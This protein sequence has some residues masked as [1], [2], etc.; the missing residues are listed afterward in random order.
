MGLKVIMIHQ[1]FRLDYLSCLLTIL[2]TILI[3]RKRWAGFV[4]AG[5]NSLLLC[6]IGFE[7]RQTGLIPANIFCIAVY[8]FNIRSWMR[9]SRVAQWLRDTRT[10]EAEDVRAGRQLPGQV[11]DSRSISPPVQNGSSGKGARIIPFP[12]GRRHGNQG[13]IA[14]R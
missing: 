10:A 8:G 6:Y 4:L 2:S 14:K 12:T 11:P 13:R 5:I 1:M 3:G 9:D 7:T